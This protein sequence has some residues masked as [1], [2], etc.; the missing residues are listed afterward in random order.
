M[1]NVELILRL[2]GGVIVLSGALLF[3]GVV[4]VQALEW[5]WREVAIAA[6]AVVTMVMSAFLLL[7]LCSQ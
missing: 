7:Y 4:G 6:V 2:L 1:S 5:G 3:Y